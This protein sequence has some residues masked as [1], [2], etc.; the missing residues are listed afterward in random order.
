MADPSWPISDPSQC[1][2]IPK[3]WGPHSQ[4][5]LQGEQ[6]GQ[7]RAVPEPGPP[8]G[9]CRNLLLLRLPSGIRNTA[10]SYR[11]Q[12]T[13]VF[14]TEDEVWVEGT[15][16]TLERAQG[17]T[18]H[19]LRSCQTRRWSVTR[20]LVV[21]K[22]QKEKS[23]NQNA[24]PPAVRELLQ[25]RPHKGPSGHQPS[26]LTVPAVRYTKA[27]FVRKTRRCLQCPIPTKKHYRIP[28]PVSH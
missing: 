21:V 9:V 4:R 28:L 15:R 19:H 11:I 24:G 20:Q 14:Q 17:H 16:E 5:P 8:A 13:P 2:D 22:Y 6:G 1:A 26:A 18:S 23:R 3:W 12:N 27:G 7:R 25:G 10:G